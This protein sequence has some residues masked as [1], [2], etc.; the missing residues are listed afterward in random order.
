MGLSPYEALRAATYNATAWLG[1]QNQLG[2]I[3][4]GKTADLM[5]LDANPLEDI[6]NV[7]RVN[8]VVLAGRWLPK[9]QL[10]PPKR[11]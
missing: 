5:L 7:R 8:G 11:P 2:T 10:L 3:E 9:A 1:V 4:P 6:A